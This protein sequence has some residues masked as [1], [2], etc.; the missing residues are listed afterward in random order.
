MYLAA[1]QSAN[2][3]KRQERKRGCVTGVQVDWYNRVRDRLGTKVW[4][5]NRAAKSGKK[6]NKNTQRWIQE[7]K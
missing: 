5:R 4:K 3:E 1:R 7:R 6:R 2:R